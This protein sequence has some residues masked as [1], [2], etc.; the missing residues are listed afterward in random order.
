MGQSLGDFDFSILHTYPWYLQKV[1]L[2]NVRST[3]ILPNLLTTSARVVCKGLGPCVFNSKKIVLKQKFFRNL[4]VY[5]KNITILLCALTDLHR[6]QNSTLL[7]SHGW[8][9]TTVKSF[10]FKLCQNTSWS[11][12][13]V[14]LSPSMFKH[15]R[16]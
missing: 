4:G 16:Q 5:H 9:C 6:V 14:T 13:T 8:L 1:A 15:G 2:K 3:Q 12:T 7:C 11:H 10:N